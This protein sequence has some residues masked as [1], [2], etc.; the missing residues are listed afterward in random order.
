MTEYGIQTPLRLG[1]LFIHMCMSYMHAYLYSLTS[2][3]PF[4]NTGRPSGLC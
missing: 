4:R 2:P 3:L 1:S